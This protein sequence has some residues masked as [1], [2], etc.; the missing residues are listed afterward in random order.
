[1]P[2]G[3]AVLVLPA[4]GWRESAG[5]SGGPTL[6]LQ[7][8][9]PLAPPAADEAAWAEEAGLGRDGLPVAPSEAEERDGRPR[10]RFGD[11]VGGAGLAPGW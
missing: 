7:V 8:E 4:G 10:E 9:E 3:P 2:E 1:M 11:R 5:A 6:R